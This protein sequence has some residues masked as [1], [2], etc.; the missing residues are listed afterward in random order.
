ME[1]PAGS[2]DEP[3]I[4]TATPDDAAALAEFAERAFRDAFGRDNSPSDIAHYVGHT[5]GEDKQRAEISDDRRVVLLARTADAVVG[6]AQLSSGATPPEVTVTPAMELERFYIGR[7]WHGRGLAQ[8]LM[9]RTVQV[10]SQ[11]RAAALWLG[12]WE[13]NARAI[14]F[15]RKSD[16]VDV[17]CKLFVLGNDRQTDRIMCRILR[18]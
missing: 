3:T 16:F 18:G 17:G 4:L 9:Q 6:Y 7:D 12:V 5:Y 8:R 13:R 11:S 1:S 10:A 2:A 14:A 15:Y